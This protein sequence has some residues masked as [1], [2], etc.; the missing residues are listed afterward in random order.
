[1]R[2]YLPLLV[3][4]T[5]CAAQ[6]RPA[7]ELP[8]RRLT[9][10]AVVQVSLDQ[11]CTVGYSRTVRNVSIEEKR[12]VFWRYQVRYVPNTYETDHSIPLEL[13][14]SNSVE[15]LWPQPLRGPYNAHMKDRLENRLRW[16]VCDGEMPLS[17][18]QQRIAVNWITLYREVFS[19][20]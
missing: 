6:D 1:M 4:L 2:R 18:A 8:D 15:N 11:I 19:G 13:G 20:Q 17:E 16:M 9:P 3:L 10:G 7:L 5:G 14:G 12:Q